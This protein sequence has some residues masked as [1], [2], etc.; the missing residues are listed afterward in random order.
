MVAVHKSATN[1]YG[2]YTNPWKMNIGGPG[3]GPGKSEDLTWLL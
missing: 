2:I 1:P 3:G